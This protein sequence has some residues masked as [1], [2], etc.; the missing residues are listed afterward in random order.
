MTVRQS[1]SLTRKLEVLGGSI[2]LDGVD[3]RK[4]NVRWLRSQIGLVSQEPTLFATTI[5]NNVAHGLIHTVH[6]HA[7]EDVKRKM[8]VE[9][10]KLANAHAFI[11]ELPEGY[12]TNIGERGMLLSGGQKQRIAIARAVVCD[13]PILALDEATSALDSASEVLVQ[14]ALDKAAAGRTTIS[15]A[16][17]L[18]TIKNA[19]Q[20]IVIAKG[21]IVERGTH[22]ELVQK[23]DGAYANLV[24]AQALREQEERE[25]EAL[26]TTE[27]I[28]DI[29]AEEVQETRK[30]SRRPSRRPSG[31]HRAI[32]GKSEA[33]IV[34]EKKME[35]GEAHRL[36]D[37]EIY[38]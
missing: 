33:S 23:K 38:I 9:A 30:I 1:H 20:I 17:R 8:V 34:L 29:K 4:L 10:C 19:E 21:Q 15:I 11:E 5:W 37:R 6:E 28:P 18:S 3:I 16:H 2:E 12:D 24:S 14:H 31:L 32:S 35:E 7:S 36:K 27:D 26:P 22:H 25:Q 13:P